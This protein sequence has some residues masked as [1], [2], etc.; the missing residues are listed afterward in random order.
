MY[1]HIDT[2]YRIYEDADRQERNMFHLACPPQPMKEWQNYIDLFKNDGDENAFL[3]FLHY[4]EPTINGK[5]K[6]FMGRYSL[7]SHFADVKM[8][9]VYRPTPW[10]RWAGCACPTAIQAGS[11]HQYA[12]PVLRQTPGQDQGSVLGG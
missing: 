9:Y 4:Y 2:T 12:V 1:E 8:A 5:V 7:Q 11:V 6:A 10:D 3:V